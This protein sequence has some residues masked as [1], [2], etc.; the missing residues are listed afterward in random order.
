MACACGPDGARILKTKGSETTLW[1]GAELEILPSGST[2]KH[3]HADMR[4]VGR[5]A[6]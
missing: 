3:V 2:I 6:P 4:V 1:L 5:L